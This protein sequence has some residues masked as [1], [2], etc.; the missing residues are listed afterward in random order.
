IFIIAGQRFAMLEMK[1]IIAPL[2]HNFYLEPV[3]YLK[4]VQMK[5]NIILRPSY[6]VHIKF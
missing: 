4:D 5:A 6:P 3:D 1:A 2:V